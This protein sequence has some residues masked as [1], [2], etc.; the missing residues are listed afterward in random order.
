M[1]KANKPVLIISTCL[2]MVVLITAASATDITTE[3]VASGLS[4]PT[5]VT[6][7]PGDVQRLFIVEQTGRIK[8]L[9]DGQV[10]NA[11]FLDIDGRVLSGG[12]RGLLGL[13]FH[14]DY[15][16]NGYFYVDYTTSNPR[17][18]FF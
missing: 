10:L 3:R 6:S 12:E 5:F 13:A 4:S 7:P 2:V 9:Q 14:P 17:R 8:I 15:D 18:K 16:N 11:P 1:I